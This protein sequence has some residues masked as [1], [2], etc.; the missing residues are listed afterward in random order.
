MSTES[1]IVKIDLNKIMGH[2]EL[3]SRWVPCTCGNKWCGGFINRKRDIGRD[4][5]VISDEET[6]GVRFM[7]DGKPPK[8]SWWAGFRERWGL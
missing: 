2:V 5:K 7:C 1:E 8:R 3:S 6:P 4:G